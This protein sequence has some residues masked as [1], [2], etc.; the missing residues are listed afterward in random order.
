[1]RFQSALRELAL[2]AVE[3]G[4]ADLAVDR[5]LARLEV[6]EHGVLAAPAAAP[7]VAGRRSGALTN[8][9]SAA[10]RIAPIKNSTLR[11]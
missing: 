5:L 4:V 11:G 3:L 7:S 8:Q 9:A 10:S 6:G 1:M 2:L